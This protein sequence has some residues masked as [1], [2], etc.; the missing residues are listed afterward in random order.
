MCVI[1]DANMASRFFALD[2]ELLPLWKWIDSG[3]AALV[4]GGK[5][6]AELYKVN[7]A[8]DQIQEWLRAGLAYQADKGEVEAE[9]AAIARRCV[10]NDAH[11]IALARVSRAQL[12]CSSDRALHRDF[13]NTDLVNDPRGS[14]YQNSGHVSRLRHRGRCPHRPGKG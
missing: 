9:E 8:R 12:L 6:T 11:V 7:S 3:K 13:R 10:S 4:V 14:V 1:V 2:A 5:L